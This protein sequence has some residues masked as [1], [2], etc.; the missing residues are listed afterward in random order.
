MFF[1]PLSISLVMS[2]PP[3][4]AFQSSAPAPAS[5][6][7]IATPD[8]PLPLDPSRPLQSRRRPLA[9]AAAPTLQAPS[10]PAP[11]ARLASAAGQAAASPAYPSHQPPR[12]PGPP[13]PG[14]APAAHNLLLSLFSTPRILAPPPPPPDRWLRGAG[15]AGSPWR[16]PP[17]GSPAARCP[18]PR[19]RWVA[20]G[21]LAV[22]VWI[23]R[24]TPLLIIF[25]FRFGWCLRG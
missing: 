22:L 5:H 18:P 20:W 12:R 1:T 10:C 16:S 4:T 19:R 14:R 13:P 3:G 8:S 17:L 7:R 24:C 25:P 23:L 2:R 11:Q 21:Q 9:S 15:G 6:V